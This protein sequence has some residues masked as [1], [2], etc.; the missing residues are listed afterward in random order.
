MPGLL[1]R[2]LPEELHRRLKE[3]AAENR[4]SMNQEV[5]V[6]LEQALAWRE[7]D[8][9]VLP[10]AFRGKFT[11]DNAWLDEAKRGGRA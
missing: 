10:K 1:I 3:R 4:R 11:L 8:H 9:E 5:I 7:Q 2:D 6:L